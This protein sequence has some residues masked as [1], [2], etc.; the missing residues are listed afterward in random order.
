MTKQE[1]KQLINDYV[2]TDI[3]GDLYGH[4]IVAEYIS[5]EF[6]MLKNKIKYL[7]SKNIK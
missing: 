7:E 3:Y 2:K 5:T 6:E 1:I 4:D